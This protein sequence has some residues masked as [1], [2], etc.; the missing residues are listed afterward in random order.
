MKQTKN[1]ADGN[2]FGGLRVKL[3]VLLYSVLFSRGDGEDS[4]I[5]ADFD[6]RDIENVNFNNKSRASSAR[7]R[8][9]SYDYL[10]TVQMLG[11]S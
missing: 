9:E 7:K 2:L 3:Q 5:G 6:E 10:N 4:V 11:Q 8:R 1:I